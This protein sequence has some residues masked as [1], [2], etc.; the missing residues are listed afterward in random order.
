MSGV[1]GVDGLKEARR[2]FRDA[3]GKTR[4]LSAA[5]RKVA[6]LATE[7]TKA[8]AATGTRQQAAAA[9]A[10]IGRGTAAGADLA[11]RNTSAVPFG[12]GAFFGSLR[13]QQFPMWVGNTWDIEAGDGPYIIRDVLSDRSNI[14]DFQDKFLEE[15]GSALAAVGL[16]IAN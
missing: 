6:Q 4:D 11:V 16:D 12:K 10:L 8:R 14:E 13:W 3:E 2:A 15:F 1:V 5:H 7:R 9:K